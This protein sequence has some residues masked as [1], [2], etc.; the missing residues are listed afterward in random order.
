MVAGFIVD[1]PGF[2]FPPIDTGLKAKDDDESQVGEGVWDSRA[3]NGPLYAR[4]LGGSR[5]VLGNP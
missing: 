1:E 5:G 4:K 2:G 3:R